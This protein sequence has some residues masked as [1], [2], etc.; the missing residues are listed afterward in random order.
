M[1]QLKFREPF[2]VSLPDDLYQDLLELHGQG[3][4]QDAP[5]QDFVAVLLRISARMEKQMIDWEKR[6]VVGHKPAQRGPSP[7]CRILDL[8]GWRQRHGRE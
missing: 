3:D 6:L 4:M 8:A 5:F 1:K 7:R 2:K